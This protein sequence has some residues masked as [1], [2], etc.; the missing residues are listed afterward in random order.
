MRLEFNSIEEFKYFAQKYLNLL[1][2]EQAI[3]APVEPKSVSPAREPE[4]VPTQSPQYT[5]DDLANAAGALMDTNMEGLL[6]LLSSFGV[7][8]LPELPAKQYPAFAA[9]LRELG[10]A[11]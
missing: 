5:V 1:P 4:P 10:G 7:Q 2:A 6:N 8:S 3:P 9:G 11:I